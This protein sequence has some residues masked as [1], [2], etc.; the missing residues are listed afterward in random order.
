MGIHEE[1]AS[2]PTEDRG[3]GP[4]DYRKFKDPNR[5]NTQT[6]AATQKI[7]RDNG[8]D[9]LLELPLPQGEYTTLGELKKKGLDAHSDDDGNGIE[10]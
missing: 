8:R 9:K 5:E 1:P 2:R 10:L 6:R 7:N 3:S 4:Q